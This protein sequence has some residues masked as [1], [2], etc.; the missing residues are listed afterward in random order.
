MIRAGA[1]DLVVTDLD[2]TLWGADE[3]I[4][5]VTLAALHTLAKRDVPVLVATGRRFGGA[6]A[7]LAR[8]GLRLPTVVL[9]GALGR[10]VSDDRTFHQAAFTPE[11]AARVL[12]AFRAAGLSPCVYVDRPDAEVVV[13][14]ACS[15]HPRHLRAVG[16]ALARGD[17][18]TLVQ[19]EP[20]LM[21]A[22]VAA[23]T[24]VMRA[25]VAHIGAAGAATITRDVRYGGATVTVR[26]PG[27]SKWDGVTAWCAD[28]GLDRGRVLAV[29]DGQ[30]D[31]ELLD[32]AR[33]A[34]VVSDGCDEAL[35]LAHHVLEPACDGGW[36]AVLDFV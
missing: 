23:P 27:I 10:D 32:A 24:T 9:D 31:L 12:D 19:R 34:C 8:H 17:L 30:N 26:A 14:A 29:G 11:D 18:P 28:Q 15:T 35:A 36:S 21:F 1:I 7:T 20:V 16:A 13:D 22:V 4:H 33:V 2:G 3:V 6:V 5:D 25:A